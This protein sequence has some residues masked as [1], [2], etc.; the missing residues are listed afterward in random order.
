[1]PGNKLRPSHQ[2]DGSGSLECATTPA[3][4]NVVDGD[5]T[6][7]KEDERESQ[8]GGGESE[9]VPWPVGRSDEAV[10][11][12]HLPNGHRQ[13]D[14]DAEGGSAREQSHEDQQSPKKLGEG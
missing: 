12:V 1:M 2:A 4:E 13:I 7:A 9:L 3:A 6:A 11:Q 14:T 10:V 8:R 5:G